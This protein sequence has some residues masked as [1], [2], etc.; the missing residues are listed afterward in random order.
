MGI[1]DIVNKL[2]VK[3]FQGFVTAV[4]TI[5]IKLTP[6]YSTGKTKGSYYKGHSNIR[7]IQK[8]LFKQYYW[9]LSEDPVS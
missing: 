5:S 3:L 6:K 7:V 1:L 8:L 9:L 2:Y 4:S